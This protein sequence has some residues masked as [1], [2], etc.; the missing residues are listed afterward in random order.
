MGEPADEKAILARLRSKHT[1]TQ[2]S[3]AKQHGTLP[4]AYKTALALQ[5]RFAEEVARFGAIHKL[6]T[7]CRPGNGVKSAE[8]ILEKAATEVEVIVPTDI[9]GAKV[10]VATLSEAYVVAELIENTFEV[11]SFE[12]RFDK[13][14]KS[15]YRDLKFCLELPGK[16][17]HVA[18]LKI[19]LESF[20]H[21]NATEHRLYEIR[22]TIDEQSRSRKIT[23]HELAVK[24]GLVDLSKRLYSELWKQALEQE[25]G[26]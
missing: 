7:A 13:P 15:G 18:E 19:V 3:R 14:E 2:T 1:L 24:N 12:D 23:R 20:D 6:R 8:R 17:R 16:P 5:T 26:G 4:A 25:G 10:I 22:R 21:F 9:L 11:C